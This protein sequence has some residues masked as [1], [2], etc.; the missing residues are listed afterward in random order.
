V[1]PN[2]K[3][4]LFIGG[5]YFIINLIIYSAIIPVMPK[6]PPTAALKK[7]MPSDKPK[8]DV[9]KLTANITPQ[10]IAD[11]IKNLPIN[12]TGF[13]KITISNNIIQPNIIKLI[14]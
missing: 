4:R 12:F 11:F 10:L 2:E 14:I 1:L 6:I 3:P 8:L 7:F 5:N 9:K 13:A